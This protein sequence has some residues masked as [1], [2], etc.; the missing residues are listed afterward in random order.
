MPSP[1]TP[2]QVLPSLKVDPKAQSKA[3]PAQAKSPEGGK[4]KHSPP[5]KED[6]D[7]YKVW[8]RVKIG[9]LEFL[10]LKGDFLGQPYIRL[11]TYQHSQLKVVI[12]DLDD[13]LR[14]EIAKQQDVEVELGF[15]DGDRKNVFVGKLYS[16]GRRPPD[17]TEILAVDPSFQM[18][19]QTGSSVQFAA[20][21]PVEK[22]GEKKTPDVKAAS[23]TTNSGTANPNQSAT[24]TTQQTAQGD[25]VPKLDPS[26]NQSNVLNTKDPKALQAQVSKAATAGQKTTTAAEQFASK[27]LGLKF[28]K[29]TP[30]ATGA[31]GSVR[32][33][34]TEMQ[35][36]AQQATLQGD[37]VVT[38]GN[39][40]RQVA[41][42]AGDPSSVVLD[43]NSNRSAFIGKPIIFKR[44]GLQLQ[45]GLGSLTVK[46]W[47][48]NGKQTVGATVVTQGAAPE[49]PTGIIAVPD[50]GQIKLDSPIF[51]GCPYTWADATKNGARVPTKEIMGRIAAIAQAI[52]PLIEKSVGKGN[53]WNITSWYRDPVSN[54]DAQGRPNSRHLYGD[55]VDFWYD[56][57]GSER[58]LFRQIEPTWQGGVAMKHGDRGFMHLDLG[59]P[60]RRWNY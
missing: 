7:R 32:V 4:D 34:Q 27:H 48:V 40:V 52:T 36:A 8:F 37:T 28:A 13:K 51:P 23:T 54:A 35:A 9:K 38:R 2:I 41:P 24:Q 60:G 31:A 16:I 29:S 1:T 33:Q 39:T 10:N 56:I 58:A 46:G 42:G 14:P 15:V 3:Q 59:P 11:S 6:G 12:N 20:E 22:P 43:Y 50:W 19:Q 30:S 26:Q 25:T 53:K 47:D 18:Q 45:S 17:G 49:H 44:T 55:A 5:Q 57:N 21:Q